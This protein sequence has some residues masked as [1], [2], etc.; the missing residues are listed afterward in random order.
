VAGDSKRQL[1]VHWDSP[2]V[3]SQYGNTFH[4]WA[5][6][7]FEAAFGGGQGHHARLLI[8]FRDTARRR[9]GGFIPSMC[10]FQ[11]PNTWSHDLPV[12]SLGYLWNRLLD[13]LAGDLAEQL[14]IG[15]VDDGWLPIT[16]ADQGL[17][18]GMVLAAM[19]YAAKHQLPPAMTNAPSKDSDPLFKYIRDRLIDSFDI[20]G[21][22]YRWLAYSSPTYPNGDE[23][24]SQVVGLA[25]GRSWVTYRDEW[26]RIRDD[27]D[28]G[29]LS[30]VGLIQTDSLSIGDNHQVVGYAYQQ[31]GQI[32]QLWIYDPNEPGQDDVVLQFDITDTAG[33]VHVKRTVGGVAKGDKRIF[34]IMRL[35]GYNPHSPPAGRAGDAVTVRQALLRSTGTRQGRI[36]V[37]VGLNRLASVR[38]WM[39]GI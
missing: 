35:D 7:D 6:P 20:T 16:H 17:C 9:V 22:G 30:P 34:C 14:G 3:D 1:Y 27:I 36:P 13:A 25:R 24:F 31:R 4:V 32:V 23:G 12:V 2:L 29:A 39:R 26:P 38:G 33:E 18:G 11:F 21:S 10:G 5:P 28:R 19:D 15:R 37:D 8:R